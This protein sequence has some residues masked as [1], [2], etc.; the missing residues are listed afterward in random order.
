[1]PNI[2]KTWN[3][4]LGAELSNCQTV[5]LLAANGIAPEGVAVEIRG[6]YHLAVSRQGMSWSALQA[7]RRMK[8]GSSERLPSNCQQ[9]AAGYK[10]DSPA[11]IVFATIPTIAPP[12]IDFLHTIVYKISYSS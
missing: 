9:G 3:A 10:Q 6:S 8:T 7:T 1:M 12:V 11:A 4:F 2:A 5:G